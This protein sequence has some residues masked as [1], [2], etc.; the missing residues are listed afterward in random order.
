M[1]KDEIKFAQVGFTYDE[2]EDLLVTAMEG[3]S[4]YWYYIDNKDIPPRD[5]ES[6]DLMVVRIAKALWN[7][8]RYKLR[9]YDLET[10]YDDEPVLLGKLSMK[11]FC[12]NIGGCQWAFDDF[13]SG[14]YDANGADAL[15]QMA[16]MNELTFG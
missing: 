12:D 13:I 11:S 3:G 15:F 1:N 2:F 5:D 16:V 7:N 9:V 6:D 14:N 10:I 8:P 4:N